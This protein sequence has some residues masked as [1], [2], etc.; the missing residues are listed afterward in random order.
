MRGALLSLI[1]EKG[2]EKR[3]V[4]LSSGKKSNFYIDCRQVT[5]HHEGGFLVGSLIY[6]MLL[7]GGRK[8]EAV[9]GMTLGADPIVSSVS[10]IAHLK[11]SPLNGFLI[12]K[13]AKGHGTA[14]RI[15]GTKNLSPGMAVAIL[16]DVVT[17]GGSTLKSIDAA[18]SFGL[19][20]ARV[21][22]IVDRNEGGKEALKNA[23]YELESLFLKEEIEEEG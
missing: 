15:E 5:L 9:G 6:D 1:R 10:V 2:Y 4:V 23:G 17:T 16:E 19:E 20:V 21:I 7:T 12:R 13:E 11:G 8:V 14:S 18:L 3:D 22:A